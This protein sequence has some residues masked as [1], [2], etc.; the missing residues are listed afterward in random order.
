[1]LIWKEI[2][3]NLWCHIQTPGQKKIPESTTWRQK[4]PAD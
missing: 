3:G 4:F 2:V 1:V